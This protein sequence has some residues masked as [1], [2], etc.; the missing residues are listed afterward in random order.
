VIGHI[1]IVPEAG[2][3]ARLLGRLDR[4]VTKWVGIAPTSVRLLGQLGIAGTWIANPIRVW[5]NGS[6]PMATGG[7]L[8]LLFVGRYGERKGCRE[9]VA[10][11]AQARAEGVH[12]TLTFVGREEYEGEERE[13]RREIEAHRLEP[14]VEFAGV[15]APAVLAS[16]FRNAD[17]ICLPSRREGMPLALLEG[18]A[19]GLPALATP[20]GGIADFVEDGRN[21]MLVQPGDVG[22]LADSIRLLAQDP[23]LRRRLG[24]AAK[25]RVRSTAGDDELIRRWREA[26]D[27]CQGD[28]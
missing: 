16:H 15:S 26:Y 14:V 8:R 27:A 22:G 1:Q 7:P 28:H 17:V 21:G 25:A 11:L 12:A 6:A 23:D 18:M 5:P 10:A 9:L 3:S 2:V 4:C 13:I 19:F 20:V 24:E